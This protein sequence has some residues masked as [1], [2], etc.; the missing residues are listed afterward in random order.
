MRIT[1]IIAKY[2]MIFILHII[3][4]NINEKTGLFFAKSFLQTKFYSTTT[5]SAFFYI[6]NV[7]GYKDILL[8]K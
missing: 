1:T 4:N 2:G 7:I 8:L 5:S 6:N 3:K